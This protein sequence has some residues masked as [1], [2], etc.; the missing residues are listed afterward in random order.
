MIPENPNPLG[1]K[2]RGAVAASDG[3]QLNAGVAKLFRAPVAPDEVVPLA[4]NSKDGD[5]SNIVVEPTLAHELSKE[6]QLYFDRVTSTIRGGGSTSTEAP[7]LRAALESLETDNG[8]VASCVQ[9]KVPSQTSASGRMERLV[10]RGDSQ[11]SRAP[12][13][14]QGA[15]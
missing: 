6:L 4:S 12:D 15:G 10:W 13:G 9:A 8:E 5:T 11:W 3:D 14:C 1:T 7:I 2:K